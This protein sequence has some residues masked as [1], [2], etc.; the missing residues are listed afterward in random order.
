MFQ[1]RADTENDESDETFLV[2]LTLQ[3]GTNVSLTRSVATG[4]IR[5]LNPVV[6]DFARMPPVGRADEGDLM[7]IAV[8]LSR[9]ADAVIDMDWETKLL[10]GARDPQ[11][12]GTSDFT[13]GSGTIQFTQGENRKTFTIQTTEDTVSERNEGF[14]VELSNLDPANRTVVRFANTDMHSDP[15]ILQGLAVIDDDEPIEM[16]IEGVTGNEGDTLEFIVRLTREHN[17]VVTVDWT[18]QDVS[19]GLAVA[20]DDYT[21]ANGTLTFQA[22]DIEKTISVV[23]I[24]DTDQ[25]SSEFFRVVLSNLTPTDRNVVKFESDNAKFADGVIEANDGSQNSEPGDPGNTDSEESETELTAR[26]ANMAYEHNGSDV[27]SFELHF[28]EDIEGFS[29]KTLK[30]AAAWRIRNGRIWNA[31]RLNPPS[32]EGWTIMIEPSGNEMVDITLP[33]TTDCAAQGAV[34]APDGRKLDNSPSFAVFGPAGLSVSDASANE[35]DGAID[36]VVSLSRQS[37]QE[38]TVDYATEGDTATE[39][40]D[41]TARSGTLTFAPG[42]FR[43]TVSVTLLDDQIDDDGETFKLKLTNAQG[44]A[45]GDGEATGTIENSDPLQKM[46]LSRFGRTVATHVTDAVS[47]RLRGPPNQASSLTVGGYRVPLRGATPAPAA[48]D[49]LGRGDLGAAPARLPDPAPLEGAGRVRGDRLPDSGPSAHADAAGSAS[50]LLE[51]IAGVLGLGSG[52]AP[53]GPGDA[54]P[55]SPW[56]NHPDPDP[57]L[58]RSQTPALDLRR[59]LLGSS[60]RLALGAEEPDSAQ[61]RLTAW[62]RFAGT[63]FNGRDGD[64]ALDGDMVTGTV[65]VD[66]TWERWLAGVAVSHSRGDGTYSGAGDRGDLEQTMTSLHPYLRY[67]VTDRLDVWGLLGYGWGQLDL[68]RDVGETLETDTNMVMGAFGGRGILLAAPESG[69]FN[70]PRARMPCSRG[71][72]RTRWRGWR[73]GTETH[74]GCGWSWKGRGRSRGRTDGACCRP[75]NWACGMIGGTRRPGSGSKWAGECSTRTQGWA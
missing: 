57:R 40:V 36:F 37:G 47:D 34:C 61:P 64:L 6:V 15:E 7:T 33:R 41:Y 19:S 2:E 71:P 55:A 5:N 12:A 1:Q 25:E 54:T 62:G 45:I 23:T 42:E 11:K 13:A 56:L 8:E 73:P 32:N 74:T 29:Y 65:G 46:W 66:G 17:A 53:A 21:A 26:F 60:F 20:G 59:L 3:S 69:A 4:T 48:A 68:E 35:A 39:G 72:P 43:K 50:L 75:W 22:G 51:G 67:A 16:K 10:G 58:G 49:D 38:I 63:Q 9:D 14:L 44:A 27:F 70:W 52:G 18:T 30:N 24:D 28:S 31:R